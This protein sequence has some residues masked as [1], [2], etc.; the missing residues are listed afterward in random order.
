MKQKVTD[1]LGGR[2]QKYAQDLHG[3]MADTVPELRG[4]VC[5]S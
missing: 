2:P 1:V 3:S 5:T 4:K